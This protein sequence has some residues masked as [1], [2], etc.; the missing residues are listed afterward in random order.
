MRKKRIIIIVICV[1]LLAVAAL[2]CYR[3]LEMRPELA[4]VGNAGGIMEEAELPEAEE[5][6]DEEP[7]DEEPELLVGGETELT[8]DEDSGGVELLVIDEML[9][10]E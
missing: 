8:E 6:V 2:T 7:V 9:P 3:G 10:L 1:L 5:P 4:A